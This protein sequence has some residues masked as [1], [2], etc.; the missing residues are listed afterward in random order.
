MR[1]LTGLIAC[2]LLTSS[3]QANSIAGWELKLVTRTETGDMY[4]ELGN[5]ASGVGGAGLVQEGVTWFN[6]G[7]PGPVVESYERIYDCNEP[8]YQLLV[9]SF[10]ADPYGKHLLDSDLGDRQWRRIPPDS[11]I[12]IERQYFCGKWLKKK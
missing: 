9:Y 1:K 6:K 12:A 7:T 10:Y 2:V 11:R 8:R 5:D 3:A 4:E